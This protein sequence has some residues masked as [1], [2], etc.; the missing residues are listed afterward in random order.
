M[1]PAR[2]KRLAELATAHHEA[3]HAVAA[4]MLTGL[5]A[6][7][8]IS[9]E[10]GEGNLG[11][12]RSESLLKGRDPEVELTGATRDRLEDQIIVS[13]SGRVAQK[14]FNRHSVRDYHSRSDR[15][16]VIHLASYVGGEGQLLETYLRW[17]DLRTEGVVVRFWP[18]VKDL[19]KTLVT[20]RHMTGKELRQW[21]L[22]WDL[23][24]LR[25]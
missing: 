22:D 21:F 18:V 2:R 11:F 16:K 9:I 6:V 20:R 19:A 23:T 8:E 17:M 5:K 12:F 1:A 25:P 24:K 14:R 13:L 4:W 10:P 15:Q 3:G 7:R